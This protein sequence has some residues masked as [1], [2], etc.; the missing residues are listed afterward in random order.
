[1][2]YFLSMAVILVVL[3]CSSK[4]TKPSEK[5]SDIVKSHNAASVILAVYYCK[6]DGW[7]K[8]LHELSN[9]DMPVSFTNSLTKSVNW[10]DF[11]YMEEGF[12]PSS[13]KLYSPEKSPG[14]SK[15]VSV[16][17]QPDCVDRKPLNF[18]NSLKV[19]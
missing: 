19:Y 1:M 6:H 12:F 11:T 2:K 16:H 7:P 14:V 10:L 9:Y 5:L 3:G 13:V 8:T 17:Q 15:A 4:P 18:K